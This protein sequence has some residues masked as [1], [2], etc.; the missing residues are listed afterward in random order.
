MELNENK[1]INE[2]IAEMMKSYG[3]DPNVIDLMTRDIDNDSMLKDIEERAL[4]G[5]DINNIRPEFLSFTNKEDTG[6]VDAEWKEVE[7]T[8]PFVLED[9]EEYQSMNE[10]TTSDSVELDAK[11]KL[12]ANATKYKKEAYDRFNHIC[13][14]I[15]DSI[16]YYPFEGHTN[17][18]RW[19]ENIIPGDA[20]TFGDVRMAVEHSHGIDVFAPHHVPAYTKARAV[21]NS[22]RDRFIKPE[23][24]GKVIPVDDPSGF[25]DG[26]VTYDEMVEYLVEECFLEEEA[27]DRKQFEEM[28]HPMV[29]DP[30]EMQRIWEEEKADRVHE[31]FKERK[32]REA[33]FNKPSDGPRIIADEQ[34]MEI[35]V[36]SDDPVMIAY[37]WTD[38]RLEAYPSVTWD[39]EDDNYNEP[40]EV[41]EELAPGEEE[42][43][44]HKETRLRLAAQELKHRYRSIESW[45][46]ATEIYR[47]YAYFLIEKHGGKKQYKFRRAIGLANEWF[48][49]F[50]VLKKNKETKHF[51][52]SGE[53]FIPDYSLPEEAENDVV[54]IAPDGSEYVHHFRNNL[55]T[56]NCQLQGKPYHEL[57][58]NFVLQDTDD[59]FI[60]RAVDTK[61]SAARRR[62]NDP[63]KASQS[64][65]DDLNYIQDFSA[66]RAK[67][68]AKIDKALASKKLSKKQRKKLLKKRGRTATQGGFQSKQGGDDYFGLHERFKEYYK[69]KFRNP[70][71]DDEERYRNPDEVVI[72]K[73]VWLK[74][75]RYEQLQL[76]DEFTRLGIID[77][78]NPKQ[79]L[80]KKARK[81]K[82]LTSHGSAD[83]DRFKSKKK[84]KKDKKKRKKDAKKFKK[85]TGFDSTKGL[86]FDDLTSIINGMANS[87]VGR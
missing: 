83:G 71:I 61:A 3:I 30:D 9:D 21:F 25:G 20:V 36:E 57:D 62:V 81:V 24:N 43:M 5:I 85:Q 41:L 27:L 55:E 17:D 51:I 86:G 11:A 44:E 18:E 15:P 75:E 49:F 50:P 32:E 76:V 84:R 82:V 66:R 23:N 37:K 78:F 13:S 54:R 68:I 4:E 22:I 52:E 56:N 72:Y 12:E 80:P 77:F 46:E 7:E 73:D 19:V 26:T 31:R 34:P 59:Q 69:E 10:T 35:P 29:Q 1:K 28:I 48:P 40:D 70:Y 60:M 79:I 67:A 65:L 33:L 42:S 8:K 16:P 63:T 14:L 87:A 58:I 38:P 45:I 6:V 64:V 39:Y 47:E 74:P 53:D 2:D